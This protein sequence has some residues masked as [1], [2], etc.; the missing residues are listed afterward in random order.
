MLRKTNT[1]STSVGQKI[2]KARAGRKISQAD[3]ADLTGLPVDYL[4]RVES[5]KEK[6]PVGT[7][8]QIAGALRINTGDFL[9]APISS[10]RKRIRAYTKRTENYAYKTLT[11]G[12]ENKHLKGFLVTID[13]NR[14]HDGVDYQHEGEEFVYVRRGQVEITIGE[15]VNRLAEGETLHFNSAIRHRMRNPGEGATELVVVIYQ[16]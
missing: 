4:K 6:P 10:L 9:Q 8:L 3:L 1:E 2:R 11:P 7:L 13:P 14:E 12:A 5:G 15:H 16:P